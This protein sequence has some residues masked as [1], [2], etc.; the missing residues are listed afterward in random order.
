MHRLDPQRLR[1]LAAS[2]SV[3]FAQAAPFPHAVLDQF[4]PAG[5]AAALASDFPKP[6]APIWADWRQRTGHQYGKQGTRNSDQFW[7]L[8]DTLYASLL[9]FN[10]HVF[11]SFF[12][13]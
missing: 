3:G 4:L 13:S 11:R 10:S 5:H 1:Q 6:D 7:R 8:P 12:N 2:A 9:E